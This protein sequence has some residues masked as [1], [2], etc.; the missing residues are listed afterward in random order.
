MTHRE[1]VLLDAQSGEGMKGMAPD[2]DPSALPPGLL[3]RVE[4]M[5][6]RQGKLQTRG[7]CA[8][9]MPSA[10]PVA[11]GRFVGGAIVPDSSTTW[12]AA[13]AI[14]DPSAGKVRI[15]VNQYTTAWG[16]WLESTASAGKWG[17]TRLPWPLSGPVHFAGI[18]GVYGTA[19]LAVQSGAEGDLPRM[20]RLDAASQCPRIHPLAP[21]LSLSADAPAFGPRST[22]DVAG[23]SWTLSGTGGLAAT[24]HQTAPHQCL[25]FSGA[26][27]AGAA[28]SALLAGG[29]D[30]TSSGQL[31]LMASLTGGLSSWR[32]L[33][34]E[35]ANGA[36]WTT[37]YDPGGDHEE[38]LETD[39]CFSAGGDVFRLYAFPLGDQAGSLTSIRGIRL[40]AKTALDS[41]FRLDVAM[42]ALGGQVPV[43]AQYAVTL[44]SS[45]TGSESPGVVLM[46]GGLGEEE[47]QDTLS[48]ALR[49]GDSPSRSGSARS[50]LPGVLASWGGSGVN[51]VIPLDP[52]L[53][54]AAW[55]PLAI[56]SLDEAQK[57]G[58]SARIYRRD[59]GET[60]F[61]LA[62][63]WPAAQWTGTG[64]A[65]GGLY[66]PAAGATTWGERVLAEENAAPHEKQ[67][68]T[69][70]PDGFCTS[71][72]SG[73][74]MAFANGRLYVGAKGGVWASEQDQPL[75]FRETARVEEGG[76]DEDAGGI[77]V[78]GSER[79]TALAAQLGSLAGLS[80]LFA[81]T[82][83]GLYRIEGLRALRMSDEGCR[84][85][86]SVQTTPE[87][88]S[89]LTSRREAGLLSARFQAPSRQRVETL[90]AV[91]SDARL[92]WA[93]ALRHGRL[94]HLALGQDNRQ[95]LLYDLEEGRW[96]SVD[97]LPEGLGVAQF[98]LWLGRP[99]FWSLAGRLYSWDDP[100]AATDD[101]A[102]IAPRIVSRAL[103]AQR[104][105]WVR[106][107]RCGVLADGGTGDLTLIRRFSGPS[108][109]SG[110][111]ITLE[112]G[113]T[114]RWDRRS[115]GSP[116]G[117]RGEKAWCELTGST[118]AGW[119]IQRWTVETRLS[120]RGGRGQG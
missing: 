11:G 26:G 104:G 84:S 63:E 15:F 31:W 24:I 100:A 2:L 101:G 59:P 16:G 87:G 19:R 89:W 73:G 78:T 108:P 106:M 25:R 37:L 88:L 74:P 67:P 112:P 103:V 55:V 93:A 50:R 18:P 49:H 82:P 53:L 110:G 32:Q 30:A 57:G 107:R 91:I 69:I 27:S 72:P 68:G 34:L 40:T 117:G 111:A 81:F 96:E 98:C 120:S 52:G 36:G 42:I 65:P 9:L 80:S 75:R 83:E 39:P 70:L 95:V 8:P 22:L 62:A 17:D 114:F 23:G 21:P 7:G 119:S 61:L 3:S 116:P 14:H 97:Q 41:G 13:A 45:A 94:W 66:G 28:A 113:L 4:N 48:R 20:I 12:L 47:I 102:P 64:F 46:P 38:I 54:A 35:A 105:G 90:L 99:A 33:K 51:P 10:P 1:V 115:D 43:G 79:P 29:L 85:P 118:P 77:A 44:Y 109:W 60:E 5:R 86:F 71:L 56:P 6:Y 92:P 58:D 76:I